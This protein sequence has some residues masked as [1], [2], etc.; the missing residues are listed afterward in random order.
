MEYF[1]LR[2]YKKDGSAVTGPIWLAPSGDRLYGYTPSRSW[3]VKRLRRDPRVEFAPS[4]FHGT[5]CGEWR[6]GRARVL[7]PAELR[8]AKRAMTAKYGNKFRW[9]TIVLLLGRGRRNGGAA[10]GIEIEPSQ[11]EFSPSE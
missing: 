1:A 4:D 9:F 2:T 7:P 11:S 5:P 6:S 10:V 8:T 3:K